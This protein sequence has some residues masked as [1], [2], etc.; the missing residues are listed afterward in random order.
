MKKSQGRHF[1][2]LLVLMAMCWILPTCLTAAKT[3]AGRI[4]KKTPEEL[5]KQELEQNEVMRREVMTFVKEN[6][7]RDTGEGWLY[8]G[9][10][11]QELK[12]P[13][14]AMVYLR[15]LLR[16][17]HIKPEVKWEAQL[18][19]AEILEKDKKDYGRALKE[20]DRMI[21]WKPDREFLVRAKIARAK[22]LGRNLTSIV[23]LQKAFKRFYWPFPEKSDVEAI[24]YIMGFER[25]YD[26]EIAMRALD[27]WDEISGFSE[28]EA[29]QLAFLRIGMLHAFD[30]NNPE[31]ARPFFEK[32]TGKTQA[33]IDAQFISAVLYHFYI[34]GPTAPQSME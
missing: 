28:E 4:K 9:R 11:Y 27:A 2:A 32:I 5:K 1:A 20:L 19:F 26:L 18:L 30:L 33:A 8:L 31:R 12:Q 21:S 15:T 29:R 6:P 17:D 22:L 7:D 16:S 3:E 10:H 13:D 25:G 23:E 24:D 34:K 14:Q